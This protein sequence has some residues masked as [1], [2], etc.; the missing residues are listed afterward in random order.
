MRPL[1]PLVSQMILWAC[2]LGPA[3]LLAGLMRV[4]GLQSRM[5]EERERQPLHTHTCSRCGRIQRWT[6]PFDQYSPC[7]GCQIWQPETIET[8]PA[9]QR[10]TKRPYDEQ[11]RIDRAQCVGSLDIDL[12]QFA[13]ADALRVYLDSADPLAPTEG[14]PA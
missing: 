8:H 6:E 5:E 13:D 9:L 7:R 12:D 11:L 4:S 1:S 14:P 3:L 10:A 2:I